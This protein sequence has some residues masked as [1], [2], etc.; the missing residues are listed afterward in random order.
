M[1][2]TMFAEALSKALM[3]I[4]MLVALTNIVVEVLKALL[5]K[6]PTNYLAIAVAML[7]TLLAFFVWM[8]YM[9]LAFIWYYLAAAMIMGMLVAYAA[10][11]GFDKLKEAF[12]RLKKQE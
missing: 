9:H 5:P 3:V 8:A 1:D 7:L 6:V 2:Y 4:A 11:F 10:M 12:E